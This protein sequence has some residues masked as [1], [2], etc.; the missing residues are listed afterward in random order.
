MHKTE[1]S[2]LDNTDEDNDENINDDPFLNN[3]PMS[4]GK[5]REES[6]H[7]SA[8]PRMIEDDHNVHRSRDLNKHRITGV[9]ASVEVSASVSLS[10]DQELINKMEG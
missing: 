2:R 4:V 9:W 3:A 10:R 8:I 7:L 6:E 1:N 5:D